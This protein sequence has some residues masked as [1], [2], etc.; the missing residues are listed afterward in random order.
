MINKKMS[1]LLSV[2]LLLSFVLIPTIG[3]A[4]G[5]SLRDGNYYVTLNEF[6]ALKEMY[7]K[8]NGSSKNSLALEQTKNL[9]AEDKYI[10]N[11]SWSYKNQIYIT[12]IYLKSSSY[13]THQIIS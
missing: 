7:N 10:L 8:L 12:K 11:Y 5:N 4:Q 2:C 13:Q 6:E 9:T 1:T 3:S